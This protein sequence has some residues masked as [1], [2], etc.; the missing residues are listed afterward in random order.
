M[1]PGRSVST[2]WLPQAWSASTLLFSILHYTTLLSVTMYTS[3]HYPAD[4]NLCWRAT[5]LEPRRLLGCELPRPTSERAWNLTKWCVLQAACS[6]CTCFLA[7]LA[8][9]RKKLTF[10]SHQDDIYWARHCLASEY[11]F[12]SNCPIMYS[13]NLVL[14]VLVVNQSN[15]TCKPCN[16]CNSLVGL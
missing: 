8:C 12:I 4:D 5:C 16:S 10:I 2:W 13:W 7:C 9:L 15:T 14:L 6:S 3:L 11:S 1:I